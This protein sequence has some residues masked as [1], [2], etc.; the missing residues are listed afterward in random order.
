VP[1][2][3]GLGKEGQLVPPAKRVESRSL[4]ALALAAAGVASKVDST[5]LVQSTEVGAQW[6]RVV[7]KG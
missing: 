1:P 6:G 7:G 5:T 3:E 4:A 2:V